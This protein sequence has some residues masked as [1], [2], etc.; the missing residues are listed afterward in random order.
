MKR[1]EKGRV[2]LREGGVRLEARLG[3]RGV[4]SI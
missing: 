1:E 3:G 2:D 4:D